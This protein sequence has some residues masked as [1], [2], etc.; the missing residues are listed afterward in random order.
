MNPR[1]FQ[2]LAEALFKQGGPARLRSAIS[3]AYYA[4]YLVAADHVRAT[5]VRISKSDRAH[6]EVSKYLASCS[7]EEVKRAGSNLGDL[8]GFRNKADYELANAAPEKPVN[9]QT[10]VTQ[11]RR[12]IA[13]LDT[14]FSDT[15]RR[16]NII[17]DLRKC[18]KIL[19]GFN[20]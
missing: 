16:P 10:W 3:R 7:D 1:D 14:S 2:D 20:R 19:H 6:A 15:A 11:A 9:A 17:A 18:E 5:G 8:R 13:T 12:A 4:A